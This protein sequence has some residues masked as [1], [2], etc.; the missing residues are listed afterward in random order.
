MLLNL[1]S[2]LVSIAAAILVQIPIA[3]ATGDN[4][5]QQLND[6]MLAEKEC[7]VQYLTNVH[8][9]ELAGQ[10]SISTRVHCA[11]GRN[12]D[13]VRLGDSTRFD[14]KDCEPQVC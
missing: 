5:K 10:A 4:W 3:W 6:Q 8:E 2:R 14:V 12:F 13:A 1:P 11:D 7:T 9:T